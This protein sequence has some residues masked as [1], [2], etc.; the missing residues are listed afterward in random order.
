MKQLL[1]ALALS[2][3][4]CAPVAACADDDLVRGSGTL[5]AEVT[6]VF[7]EHRGFYLEVEEPRGEDH[8]FAISREDCVK[9]ARHLGQIMRITYRD[10]QIMDMESD[11]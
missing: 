4:I 7:V 3:L 1:P 2:A 10:G 9:H 6:K 8:V 5:R 11:R